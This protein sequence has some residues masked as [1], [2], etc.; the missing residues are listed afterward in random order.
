VWR[1]ARNRAET[2]LRWALGVSLF[3]QTLM[4]FAVSYFGQTVLVW[5]LV[6]GCIGSLMVEARRRQRGA[7]RRR[8]VGPGA[9]GRSG[10]GPRGAPSS[11][12]AR[13]GGAPERPAALGGGPVPR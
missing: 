4:F 7:R 1:S 6:L 12:A 2:A 3:S 11:E 10:A 13:V 8:I 5:Y 9:H